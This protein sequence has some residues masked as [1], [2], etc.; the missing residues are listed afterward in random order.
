M[1]SHHDA[2][3]AAL[4]VCPPLARK[5]PTVEMPRN[6]IEMVIAFVAEYER[7][8]GRAIEI[9]A[10]IETLAQTR[11]VLCPEQRAHPR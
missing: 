2:G 10:T 4:P 6:Q 11:M 5:P 7:L 9:N 1:T 3:G 8:T